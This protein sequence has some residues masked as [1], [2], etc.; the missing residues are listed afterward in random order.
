MRFQYPDYY[1]CTATSVQISLNFIAL[2][3][4]DTEWL[5]DASYAA[6][7]EIFRFERGHMTLPA[8]A[9]GSDPHGTRNAMNY[10]G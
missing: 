2:A 3:G 1:S 4:G 5:L 6:Q 10:F 8:T 7:E 9:D